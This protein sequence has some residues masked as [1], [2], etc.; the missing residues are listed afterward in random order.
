MLRPERFNQ[1]L[2]TALSKVVNE[3]SDDWDEHIDAVAFAYRINVQATTRKSPFELLYGVTARLPQQLK[4]DGGE[5]SWATDDATAEAISRRVETI[6]DVLQQKRKSAQ[7]N[8]TATQA[9]QKKRFDLKHAPPTFSV[10][11]RVLKYNRRRDTR[12]G[13][14]LEKRYQGPYVVVEVMGKGTYR[15]TTA[16]GS[17]VKV[18]ANSRD[19]KHFTGDG[20]ASPR[21]AT[22]VDLTSAPSEPPTS[23]PRPWIPAL[24]LFESDRQLVQSAKLN[25]RCVDAVNTLIGQH[26]GQASQS[27]VFF[28]VCVWVCCCAAQLGH[29]HT[30]ARA[31]GRS[32]RHRRG[33]VLH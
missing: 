23:P 22:T 13:D 21:K 26:Q 28:T 25:D 12:K 8:I 15:L 11:D 18:L 7:E 32:R 33:G 17:P 20:Y 27:T 30:R 6:A 16:N 31:L 5:Y 24:N 9:K 3:T 14:K 29:D 4:D 10:G 19:L 2:V 1:T